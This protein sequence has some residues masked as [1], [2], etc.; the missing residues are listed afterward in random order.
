MGGPR[1]RGNVDSVTG[2]IHS[3]RAS[4]TAL[5]LDCTGRVPRVLHWGADLG[6]LHA[7][8]LAALS[9]SAWPANPALPPDGTVYSVMPTEYEGWTGRPGLSGHR[10]GRVATPR[11]VTESVEATAMGVRA[12]LSDPVAGLAVRV[13][14]RMTAHG[15][16]RCS[17]T[18]T[19]TAE[20][21]APFELGELTLSMPLPSRATEVADFA[22]LWAH[23]RAPQRSALLVGEHL[24]QGRRGKPGAD[25]PLLTQV[26]T[27]GFGYRRGEVYAMHVAFSG[28][29]LSTVSLLPDGAGVNGAT[30]GGGESLRPGEIRLRAGEVYTTP[31]IVFVWS[32][33]GTDSLS[34]RVHRTLRDR[35]RHP[36]TP[37]PLVLNNWEATYFDHDIGRLTALV[38]RAADIGVERFVLDDG[39]FGD[40]RTDRAGLGDWTVSRDVWPDGLWPLVDRVRGAGM[41]FGLWVEPEMVNLDSAMARAHPEWILGPSDGLGPES[42]N[43][44]V[45]DLTVDAAW[46][47]LF[48]SISALVEEYSIDYL[49]WDHNRD[50]LEAVH[51]G[52]AAV[53]S[54]TDA[55]YQLLDSLRAAFPAL[56]IESCA[57]GGARVDLGILERADRVWASD[58]NDP[59]ER[60]Q[61][62][63][64]TAALLPLELIGVHVGAPRSHTT[65]R[66]T[67]QS[68]RMAIALFGH[69]GIEWDITTCSGEEL[70]LLRAWAA[71]YREL[72]FLLHSGDLVHAD[73]DDPGIALMGVV[74]DDRSHAVYC[75]SRITTSARRSA[76]RIA[77]PGLDPAL[78]YRVRLREELGP[79][80]RQGDDPNWIRHVPVV[81]G[82]LL[83]VTGVPLPNLQPNQALVI[84]ITAVPEPGRA[85]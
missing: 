2:S 17:A 28:D 55:L 80:E 18:V 43:Q 19:N 51:D 79:V 73:L 67:D 45:V 15:V 27:E 22:G 11:F 10:S 61:I 24:R 6:D 8:D 78:H 49:K 31:E 4:G 64:G 35:P 44:H 82:A 81:F 16:L 12:R 76:G 9:A 14:Y 54:Q 39:W 41:Q 62:Q 29:T 25:A 7:D 48:H 37:R 60:E 26:G 52:R 53:H 57:S 84:E 36:S 47:Y 21:S 38:E 65:A 20:D 71:T 75:W 34:A 74:S 23:E 58:T 83:S 33:E 63:R 46:Q 72:R 85:P 77:F 5:I 40:R 30:L 70:T 42:R 32:G 3:L 50:L 66:I 59:V 68:Y 69:A 1:R 56:E 13:D